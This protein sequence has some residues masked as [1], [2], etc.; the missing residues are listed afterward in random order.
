MKHVVPQPI[1]ALRSLEGSRNV[2][3][4]A[5]VEGRFRP[6]FNPS[7]RFWTVLRACAGHGDPFR[8]KAWLKRA[9]AHGFQVDIRVANALLHAYAKVSDLRSAEKAL[10]QMIRQGHHPSAESFN[11]ILAAC[12]RM[13]DISSALKWFQR[14]V[15][16]NL[17]PDRVTYRTMVSVCARA[18]NLPLAEEWLGRMLDSTDSRLDVVS[19]SSIIGGYASQGD[20]ENAQR[21][22]DRM[23]SA[24]LRPGSFAFNPVICAW[25]YVNASKAE[26]W[27][28]KALE[29]GVTPSDTALQRTLAAY[30][31]DQDLDGCDRMKELL[32]DIHQWPSAWAIAL[33][34]KPYAGAGDFEVVEQLLEDLNHCSSVEDSDLKACLRVLLA[35]YARS[36]RKVEKKKV[37]ICCERLFRLKSSKDAAAMGDA[38]RALGR[39]GYLHLAERLGLDPE[40]QILRKAHGR[41]R[42]VGTMQEIT[43]G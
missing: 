1:R 21:W 3:K 15:D 31:K 20:A 5:D 27:I 24:G 37:E 2:P 32:T 19:C 4:L 7:L 17:T 9:E 23:L 12:A 33:L 43:P 40:P 39:D 13:E 28:W 30:V 38:R 14:L 25:S 11:A 8:V 35:A 26:A 41:S 29:T 42:V 34:A 36:P 10:L 6:P 16:A 18:K 22:L